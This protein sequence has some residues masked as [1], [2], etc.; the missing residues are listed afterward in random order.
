M[1]YTYKGLGVGQVGSQGKLYLLI[2]PFGV[3]VSPRS[4]SHGPRQAWRA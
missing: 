2:E 1:D 3:S 4:A